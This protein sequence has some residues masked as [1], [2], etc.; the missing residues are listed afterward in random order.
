MKHF[1]TEILE[2]YANENIDRLEELDIELQKVI[3]E[4]KKDYC[5]CKWDY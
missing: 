5:K 1:R 4:T 2:N 3:E